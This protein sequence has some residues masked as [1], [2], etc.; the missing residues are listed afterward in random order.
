MWKKFTPYAIKKFHQFYA[1]FTWDIAGNGK[2]YI[3]NVLE[4]STVHNANNFSFSTTIRIGRPNYD[5]RDFPGL[6]DDIRLYDKV[7]SAAE[8]EALYN[9][10]E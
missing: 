9:L 8:I 4:V 2:L 10:L 5:T 7:L 6:L 1:V 3:D